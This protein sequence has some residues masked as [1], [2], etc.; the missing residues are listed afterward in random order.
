ML[1]KESFIAEFDRQKQD[2]CG[3]LRL[4]SFDRDPMDDVVPVLWYYMPKIDVFNTEWDLYRDIIVSVIPWENNKYEDI[5]E[6]IR[7]FPIY[8]RFETAKLDMESVC[9][10]WSMF[11]RKWKWV[12]PYAWLASRNNRLFH[13]VYNWNWQTDPSQQWKLPFEVLESW[14]DEAGVVKLFP[15][16][17]P[18]HWNNIPLGALAHGMIMNDGPYIVSAKM[19]FSE[20]A[21]M[22]VTDAM[23]KDDELKGW[24]NAFRSAC[25]DLCKNVMPHKGGIESFLKKKWLNVDIMDIKL[26]ALDRFRTGMFAAMEEFIRN[27]HASLADTVASTGV[28][29]LE[30]LTPDEVL[31]SLFS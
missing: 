19:H 24:V 26:K 16:S 18:V 20:A 8:A 27:L 15:T 11:L 5:W 29:K 9:R 23:A 3:K 12:G 7:D 30:V 25:V 28:D 31:E 10:L 2:R 4:V 13:K 17:D 1:S 14:S 21:G 6:I 22:T